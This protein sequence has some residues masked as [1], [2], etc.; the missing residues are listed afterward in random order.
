VAELGLRSRRLGSPI[1][2]EVLDVNLAE[3]LGDRTLTAIRSLFAEN[4]VLVFRNQDLTA[5]AIA[6]FARAFGQIVPGVI[7]KYRHPD[8]PDVS[9]LTNVESDGSIDAFGVRRAS[10]WHYDGSFAESP[11][12]CAMLYG[13]KVPSDG[14]GTLFADM[15]T[16]FLTLPQNL[17]D[18]I[19]DLETINH[20]GLG[21]AGREYFD[22]MSPDRWG[23]YN[24]VRRPLVMPHP[25]TGRKLLKFCMIHTAGF[26]GMTHRDS[27]N[28]MADL[29]V[30]ATG[31]ASTYYHAW[32]TGDLVL[33]DEHATMH[34]NAGDFSPEQ[35]RVMLRAM[36]GGDPAE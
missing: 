25:I 23:A 28:F 1:G 30:Q 5:A 2:L 18:R 26:A 19:E 12:D 35:P 32:Q 6:R 33:W 27:A 24:P 34:R 21:P 36:V 17:R 22:G 3:P 13:I 8:V 7:E 14:G 11:P 10:D 15:H 29:L 31:D 9:Y 4:P 16:A 20:F